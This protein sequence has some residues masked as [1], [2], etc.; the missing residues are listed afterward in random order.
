VPALSTVGRNGFAAAIRGGVIQIWVSSQ[1]ATVSPVLKRV[2]T[3]AF[4]LHAEGRNI[5]L[6][7]QNGGILLPLVE[8]CQWQE[9]FA[10]QL[11]NYPALFLSSH[12]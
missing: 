5:V 8:G 1:P 12:D 10:Y 3:T 2:A 7:Q 4:E 6:T 9:F 11:H